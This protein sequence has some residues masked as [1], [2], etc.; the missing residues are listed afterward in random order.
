MA[1]LRQQ[2]GVSARAL[3]F[4]ILTAARSGEARGAT[5]AEVDLREGA[6]TVPHGRMKAG[7]AHRVPLSKPALAILERMAELRRDSQPDAPIF[8][9]GRTGRPLSDVALAKAIRTSR[10]RA[11]AKTY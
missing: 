7:R 11:C 4:A 3:E 8:P 6:W 9:G 5:W 2:T 1:A 10:P